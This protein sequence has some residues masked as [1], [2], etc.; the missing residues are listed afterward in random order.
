MKVREFIEEITNLNP[1]PELEVFIFDGSFGYGDVN[2]IEITEGEDGQLA[3]HIF[4]GL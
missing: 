4:S 3:L 2:K 1:D